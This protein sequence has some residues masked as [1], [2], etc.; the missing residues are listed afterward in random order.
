M[1]PEILKYNEKREPSDKV[2]CDVLA[3][4]INK[5]VLRRWLKKGKVIQ[6]DYK[7]IVRRKSKLERLK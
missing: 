7:N 6:W 5:T 2:I 4:E 3:G 1:N